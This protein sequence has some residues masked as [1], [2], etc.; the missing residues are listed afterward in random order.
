[1]TEISDGVTTVVPMMVL[2]WN[3]SNRSRSVVHAVI[4]RADPDV[5]LRAA[6]T[7]SGDLSILCESEAQANEVVAL[8]VAG[9]VLTLTED[10]LTTVSMEYVVAGDIRAELNPDTRS[11]W[12]VTVPY[13]EVVT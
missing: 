7:R 8:H 2:G 6:A 10:V 1:M 12:V 3:A 11:R 4:G 9:L 5:T 13:Q